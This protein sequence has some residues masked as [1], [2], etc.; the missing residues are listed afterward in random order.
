MKKLVVLLLI[1][2]MA[3]VADA[4]LVYLTIDGQPAPEEIVC[5]PSQ[6]FEIDV[7]S[8]T[9]LYGGQFRLELTNNQGHMEYDNPNGGPMELATQY[10]SFWFDLNGDGMM[11]PGDVYQ[12]SDWTLPWGE[13]AGT[14]TDPQNIIINGG[15]TSASATTPYDGDP[16]VWGIMFH[17]DDP[18]PVT[19]NLYEQVNGAQVE[20]LADSVVF[21]QTP[22]PMT[23]ALLG[24]GGLGLLR[25]RRR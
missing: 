21:N 24:L 25:R 15:N 11:D 17:C 6:W 7:E 23:M 8:L 9:G 14:V 13:K 1:G 4:S 16:L 22:E 12:Y 2:C 18:T 5:E 19:L 10:L 3:S 20:T